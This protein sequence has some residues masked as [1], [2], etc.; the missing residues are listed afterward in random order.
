MQHTAN[1]CDLLQSKIRDGLFKNRSN[2]IS[3][4]NK[5]RNNSDFLLFAVSNTDNS[6]WFLIISFNM[7][8]LLIAGS[9]GL[10]VKTGNTLTNSW[11]MKGQICAHLWSK[12]SSPHYVIT[13]HISSPNI[14]SGNNNNNNNNKNLHPLHNR[15][16][17]VIQLTDLPVTPTKLL[18]QTAEIQQTA[19]NWICVFG[20]TFI[21]WI[22]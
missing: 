22:I 8:S 9:F 6:Y 21:Y 17:S 15:Y 3:F 7:P 19:T 2:T 14:A 16:I 13:L 1:A 18:T 12:V 20:N 5:F 11:Q 10:A 4:Q